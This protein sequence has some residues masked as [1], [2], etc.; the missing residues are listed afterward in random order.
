M[1]IVSDLPILWRMLL[2]TPAAADHQS[3]L[4]GFYR[5]QAER[6]DAS[7]ERL[8]HGR[9]DLFNAVDLP[10]GGVLVELGGGTGRNL[11]FLGERL[12][13]LWRIYLVDLCPALLERAER[14]RRGRGWSNVVPVLADACTWR[15]PM[16]VDA[17]LCSY[18]LSMIPDWFTAVDNAQAM[19]RPGG[20]FG[21]VDFYVARR[22][23]D[24][25]L[26]RH[27]WFTRTFWPAWFG[28]DGV[29]PDADHLPYLIRHFGRL[30]LDERCGTV[31]WL[32]GVRVPWYLFIGRRMDGFTAS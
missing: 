18:S 31:P 30:R 16:P 23:P 9:Q 20:I 12:D 25:G 28:H 32:W 6:Y 24:P 1:T 8:L 5:P 27:S 4:D 22:H 19:L 21:A 2:G 15:P 13:R 10:E 11:E 29:R 7:R 3:R 26:A 17:V 14:R